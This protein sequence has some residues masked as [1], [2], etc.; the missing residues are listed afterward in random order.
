M[1]VIAIYMYMYMYSCT[2]YIS[3]TTYTP[4]T[5]VEPRLADTPELW[6][7]QLYGQKPMP[8]RCARLSHTLNTPELR[9]PTIR[10]C[11]QKIL[12]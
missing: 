2:L 10:Y 3:S 5:T 12:A 11:G 6:T 7:L 9:T 1:T 8:K 4:V